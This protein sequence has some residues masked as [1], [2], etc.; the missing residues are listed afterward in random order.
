MK[1]QITRK[2]L[3]LE[4][5]KIKKESTKL[6]DSVLQTK[7]FNL[8]IMTTPGKRERENRD[9]EEYTYTLKKY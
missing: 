2:S 6:V 9:H 5:V 1:T 3:I 7:A 4:N 8:I